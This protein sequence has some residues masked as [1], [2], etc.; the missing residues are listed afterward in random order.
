MKVINKDDNS[1][2][3]GSSSNDGNDVKDYGDNCSDSYSNHHEID[4]DDDN[5]DNNAQTMNARTSL[6]IHMEAIIF[7]HFLKFRVLMTVH[8]IYYKNRF[9]KMFQSFSKATFQ[10]LLLTGSYWKKVTGQYW[11]KVL[12]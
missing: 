9:L 6:H 10:K 11:E 2:N 8:E 5:S 7:L 1:D 4:N 3:D 12:V